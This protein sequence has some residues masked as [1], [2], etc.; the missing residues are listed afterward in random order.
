[1]GHDSPRSGTHTGP[2]GNSQPR[3]LVLQ[4]DAAIPLKELPDDMG[5]TLKVHPA[6]AE[7]LRLAL[8][9]LVPNRH[10]SRASVGSGNT[11]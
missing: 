4:V 10:S 7:E 9:Y 2:T 11:P 1:M 8:E 3:E 6:A 5:T